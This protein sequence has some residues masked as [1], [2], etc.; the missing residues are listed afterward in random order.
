MSK[1]HTKMAPFTQLVEAGKSG[2]WFDQIVNPP[3]VRSSTHL[4]H[5]EAERK[6]AQK[7]NK[8]GVFYYGRRGGPTQWALSD[9]ITNIEP[10]S[11]GTVLYPSG[12][13][14][15]VGSLMTVLRPGDTFLISDN[16]YEPSRQSALGLLKKWGVKCRFIDPLNLELFEKAFCSQT[17]AVW[18]E[19]PGSLTMEISDIPAL[20]AIARDKGAVSL[21]DNTWATSLG[22]SALELGCDI[23]VMSLTKHVG[24]HSDVMMGSASAKKKWYR[25][26]RLTSQQFGL[27]VSPDDASLMLRGLRTM[28][29]RLKQSTQSALKIAR[30]L[31]QRSEVAHVLCPMLESDPGFKIWNRDFKGGCG[32]FSFVLRGRDEKAR[33]RLVDNL[34]LFGI[35]Y[36]WGGF[37]S[38]ALPFDPGSIRTSTHWPLQSWEKADRLGVRLSIGLEDPD[39]LISD[40]SQAFEEMDKA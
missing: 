12:V 9:A 16:S 37:E 28:G 11:Y 4:Y 10:G 2:K 30:W 36:S 24:G 26:L 3:V 22:F 5:S 39:D 27:V 6:E 19:S 23:S 13:A 7:H 40:L 15:I 35:G 18:F 33:A 32:L 17:K 20:T 25:A 14:A 8:D 29:L 34:K 38:L 1:K 21:I 31:E